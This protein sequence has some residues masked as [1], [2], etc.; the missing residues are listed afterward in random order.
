MPYIEPLTKWGDGLRVLLSI[1]TDVHQPYLR[2]W[3]AVFLLGT[4]DNRESADALSVITNDKSPLFRCYAL[5]SIASLSERRAVPVLIGK[6]DDVSVCMGLSVTDPAREF[7]VYVS[8]EAVRLLELVTGQ[9]FEKQPKG[10]ATSHR[11]TKRW[12]K[13]WAKNK[14]RYASSD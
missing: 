2:R 11:A 7:D 3:H 14:Q 13:W 9:R 4:F 12:K 8:D 6:L 5:Q 10:L 1:A